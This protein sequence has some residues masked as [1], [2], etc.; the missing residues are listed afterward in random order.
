MKNYPIAES[1]FSVQ[2]E[3]CHCGRRAYFIR[4][5]GCSVRCKWC[6]SKSAWNG[7]PTEIKSAEELADEAKK[8]GAEFVVITGGEPC[9]HNLLP[10]LACLAERGIMAHLETSG[11]CKIDEAEGSKFSWVALSPKLF[12]KPLKESLARA[13]ELKLI[14]SDLSE[15]DEYSELVKDAS[16]V[17]WIWLHPEWSKA[18]D[19]KLLNG[20]CEFVKQNG[21]KYRVG[22]QM[23]KCYFVR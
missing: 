15:M 17:K 1:F 14:V 12:H 20:L 21:G 3:G 18:T 11:V 22:W 6:D 9:M 8:S 16:N 19:T 2:G 23:H 4:L 5:F 10:L 13:D 7:M